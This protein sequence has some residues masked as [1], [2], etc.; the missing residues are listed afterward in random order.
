MELKDVLAKIENACKFMRLDCKHLR[1]R[2]A[3]LRKSR[4][5]QT[6]P[7]PGRTYPTGSVT[8]MPIAV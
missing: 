6:S 3:L 2:R 7:Y 4:E 1:Y 8:G 5:G